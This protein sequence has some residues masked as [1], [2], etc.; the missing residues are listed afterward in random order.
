MP[1][2]LEFEDTFEGDAL[3]LQRW[4]PH[5]LPHWSSRERAAARYELAGGCL[6]LLIT[7]D[8]EPWCPKLDGEIRVSSL[9]TGIF[10]GPVGSTVGQHRFNANAVV[11]QPW[12]PE[13][14]TL[15]TDS[16]LLALP[17]ARLSRPLPA[18]PRA[19]NRA[20]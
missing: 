5:Y 10:A 4:I 11:R 3:D 2:V 13:R 15:A 20:G 19:A 14:A 17:T 9:Q 12:A 7:A 16:T 1:F 18:P 8:Q 6:R